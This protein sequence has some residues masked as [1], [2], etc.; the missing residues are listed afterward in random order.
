MGWRG[1]TKRSSG[2]TFTQGAIGLDDRELVQALTRLEKMTKRR[3]TQKVLRRAG[4]P[5]RADAKRRVPE[6]TGRLKRSI[7]TYVS[8]RRYGGFGRVES[9]EPYAHLV[10]LGTKPHIQKRKLRH[11]KRAR[12]WI[13]PGA[14][15]KPFLRPAFDSNKEESVGIARKTLREELDT[16]TKG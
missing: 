8:I 1:P 5:I 16:L 3:V 4:A 14:K 7:K 9:R 11:E 12:R 10:E 6:Q 2:G 15:P 13:H